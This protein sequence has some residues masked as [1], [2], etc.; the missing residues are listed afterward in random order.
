[1]ATAATQA[2]T[3]G[4]GRG[5]LARRRARTAWWFLLPWGI[6]FLSFTLYPMLDSL[7]LSFTNYD[8]LS[9][10]R[11]VGAANYAAMLSRHSL[12][13]QAL[14]VTAYYVVGSVPVGTAIALALAILL[15]QRVFG[16]GLFRTL[17]YIP[18]VVSG[19]AASILWE[20]I[21]Q[22]QFGLL[23]SGLYSLLHIANGPQWLQS[24]HTA[25]I[26]LIVMSF[27]TVGGP[28]LIYLA[29]LQGIQY[30]LYEA[31][32]VDGARTWVLFR[33]IT[34]PMLTPQILFNLVLGVIASFQ[35]FTSAYIMT[36][37][38]PGYST[39]TMVLYLY[40]A[41]FREFRMGYASAVA[42]AVFI[43]IVLVSAM[44]FR[45]LAKRVFYGGE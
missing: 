24:S 7:W 26:S 35:V 1:M 39:T 20:W 12:F 29:G 43:L 11:F 36:D 23:N 15:N 33:H 16:E 10:P 38:G 45:S 19:V 32:K 4:A 44:V 18:S 30:E 37:G 41:A 25:M 40:R 2:G 8:I 34:V 9:P 13:W 21:F 5:V 31:A 3:A 42:W 28:M 14:K 6:G 27:W 22:P 17:F